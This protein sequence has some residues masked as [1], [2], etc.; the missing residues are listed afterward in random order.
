MAEDIL[1][2]IVAREKAET[3]L[4]VEPLDCSTRTQS[5]IPFLAQNRRNT[6]LR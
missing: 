6:A 2:A 3:L 1:L 4:V 5:S